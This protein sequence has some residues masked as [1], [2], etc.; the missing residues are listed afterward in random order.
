MLVSVCQAEANLSDWFSVSLHH[1]RQPFV[2]AMRLF[3][4]Y[5]SLVEG[6]LPSR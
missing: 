4:T 1:G 2:S 3:W 5:K 6:C